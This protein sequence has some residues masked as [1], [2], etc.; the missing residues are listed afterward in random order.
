MIGRGEEVSIGASRRSGGDTVRGLRGFRGVMVW[1]GMKMGW[2][3]M[4]WKVQ[5]G[6]N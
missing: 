2:M 4:V 3:A 5:G 1:M 6:V